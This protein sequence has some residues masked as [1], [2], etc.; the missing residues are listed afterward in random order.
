MRLNPMLSAALATSLLLM[1]P[2]RAQKKGATL[3]TRRSRS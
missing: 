3:D 1:A 2:A